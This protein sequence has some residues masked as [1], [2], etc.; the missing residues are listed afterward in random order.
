MYIR[1]D[2]RSVYFENIHIIGL[3]YI[4]GPKVDLDVG[5]EMYTLICVCYV[6]ALVCVIYAGFSLCYVCVL[7]CIVTVL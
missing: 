3:V 2:L 7:V 6:L 1:G 4:S 5:R